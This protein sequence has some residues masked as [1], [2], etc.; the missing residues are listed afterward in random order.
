MAEFRYAIIKGGGIVKRY[1]ERSAIDPASIRVV[2]GL[3]MTRPI[4][5]VIDDRSTTPDKFREPVVELIFDTEVV[6][7]RV[8]RNMTAQEI[9][10]RDLAGAA[11]LLDENPIMRA[12]FFEINFVRQRLVPPLAP[13]SRQDKISRIR[14]FM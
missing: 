12:I 6:R 4:R 2:D 13:L 10:A 1:T 5:T 11:Q 7:T 9:N 8:I 14:S 3:P